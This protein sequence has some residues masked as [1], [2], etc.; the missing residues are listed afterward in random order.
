MTGTIPTELGLTSR[1]EHI[2][3]HDNEFIGTVPSE[4]A[5]VDVLNNLL[6]LTLQ[7]NQ[8]TG[9]MDAFCTQDE[10]VWAIQADCGVDEN[11]TLPFVDG[12]ETLPVIDCPCC[13]K[14]C[15]GN[16]LAGPGVISENHPTCHVNHMGAC[17]VEKADFEV[18]G[19]ILYVEGAGTVCDCVSADNPDDPED[20]ILSCIDADCESCNL[21]RSICAKNVEFSYDNFDDTLVQSYG[22]VTF[23]YTK[24]LNDTVRLI[25][26]KPSL[27]DQGEIC[28]VFING[29]KCNSCQRRACPS[30]FVAWEVNCENIP[31]GGRVDVCDQDPDDSGPLTVFALQDETLLNGCPPRFEKI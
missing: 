30:N 24:G 15:D 25:Q 6:W 5:D 7:G 28:E 18:E 16:A 8:L 17:E 26:M 12:N 3:L 31:G 21:D 2:W 9:G 10:I 14:C 1:L 13:V 29:Q 23:Q 22:S 20:V 19:A 11:Y 27:T 4:I